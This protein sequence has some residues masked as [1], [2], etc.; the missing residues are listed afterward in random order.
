MKYSYNDALW[1]IEIQASKALLAHLPDQDAD[2]SVAQKKLHSLSKL[3]ML[4]ISIS[5]AQC[6]VLCHLLGSIGTDIRLGNGRW[7]TSEPQRENLLRH[8][9]RAYEVSLLRQ[10][11]REVRTTVVRSSRLKVF[12]EIVR[13]ESVNGDVVL[14]DCLAIDRRMHEARIELATLLDGAKVLDPEHL[15]YEDKMQQLQNFCKEFLTMVVSPLGDPL[16][17][18]GASVTT[19]SS[20]GISVYFFHRFPWVSVTRHSSRSSRWVETSNISASTA[21]G[22]TSSHQ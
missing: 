17:G 9:A 5:T 22:P 21:S 19:A 3:S 14:K 7:K 16:T 1:E 6:E 12:A 10:L 15:D 4:G 20:S 13:G 8:L 11:A 18:D 2:W